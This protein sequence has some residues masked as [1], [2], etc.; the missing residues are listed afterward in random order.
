MQ[1]VH[2]KLKSVVTLKQIKKMHPNV[3]FPEGFHKNPSLLRKFDLALLTYVA[4]P[5]TT[6]DQ[7]LMPHGVT[8]NEQGQWT[9]IWKVVDLFQDDEEQTAV[10]KKAAS[11]E[12][13]KVSARVHMNL[14]MR[15]C[16]LALL[17]AGKLSSVETA[18]ESLE[19]PLKS[20]A[21]IEWEY[22]GIVERNSTF[23]TTLGHL[24]G[25]DADQLDELFLSARS[26]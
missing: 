9:Q 18:I 3:S 19:E 2:T 8:Q 11:V 13:K 23:V 25:F 20:A 10:E 24:I 16:R 21:Q 5:E 12:A 7:G 15:Q 1:Y 14:T 4:P 26:L 22:A 17:E 6:E